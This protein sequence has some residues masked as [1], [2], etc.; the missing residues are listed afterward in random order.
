M[1]TI[2]HDIS[3]NAPAG[4]FKTLRRSAASLAVMAA[5]VV[6]G[7][8]G[9]HTGWAV[10]QWASAFLGNANSSGAAA[11]D[12]D[13][14]CL[15]HN[16]PESLCIA[17]NEDLA[18]AV[19][20]FGWCSEHGITQ[21][22]L[23]HP[24]VAQLKSIPEITPAD[25]QRADRAL[26]L[27]PRPENGS[28]CTH[29]RQRIQF[30]SVESLD[31]AGVDIAL[32][33]RGH[34]LE[35][36]T[37]HGEIVYDQ[38]RTANLASRVPG[39]V[40]SVDAQ[41][42]RRVQKGE[43]LALIDSADIG[44]AKS[45]FLQ[46]VADVRLKQ[47]V[48]DRLAPLAQ[49]GTVPGRQFSEAQAA[50]EE[51]GIRLRTAEQALINL[52]L[53]LRAGD[54]AEAA[55]DQIA[56]AIQFLGLPPELIDK[57]KADIATSNLFPLRAPLD[58]VVV[59]CNIVPGEVVG[60]TASAFTVSDVDHMWLQLNVRQEDIGHVAAG[61]PVRFRPS[62]SQAN[63]GFFGA[64]SW[65]STESD[66]KTRTV[67]VRVDLPNSD[68]RLKAYTFGTGQIVLRDE[69]EAIMV[70]TEAVHTDGD[71]SIVFVR[72]KHF[73][74]KDSP[75][76]FHIREVRTGVRNGD[77]TEIIAGVLP[78]EVIASKNS[79]VLEAQLMKSNLGAGCGC[80][81]PATK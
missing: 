4:A 43:V 31:K 28:H 23:H 65:I 9:H 32:V 57:L 63:D 12:A 48:F 30:A 52:G 76:F 3:A 14:W 46:A 27:L 66:E 5:L 34:V 29:Y 64:I 6:A 50:L 62:N 69:P 67:K 68:R 72:D 73:L 47:T 55:T 19:Q 45:D 60:T 51:A 10:P 21:C 54:F 49:T 36:V 56:D 1:A 20:D 2:T 58:G 41:V 59:A 70:P 75:K 40:H 38:T 18:P 44:K 61:Q 17:C 11:G 78:G 53:P 42:G 13:D 24:E 80:C 26:A 79:M 15:E 7:L 33:T 8:W 74:K 39:A 71:C 81:A 77:Q 16:V 22:P 35:A 25:F 37:A